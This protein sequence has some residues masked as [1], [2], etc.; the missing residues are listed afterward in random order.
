M[1]YFLKNNQKYSVQNHDMVP[2]QDGEEY[3]AKIAK[4][5]EDKNTWKEMN[6]TI[7]GEL[8]MCQSVKAQLDK[9]VNALNVKDESAKLKNVEQCFKDMQECKRGRAEL[10]AT[11]LS[12][13]EEQKRLRSAIDLANKDA[14]EL[15]QK[16]LK[17]MGTDENGL[18]GL[19]APAP[20]LEDIKKDEIL[21]KRKL[22]ELEKK[23]EDAL[24]P[25]QKKEK[26]V[27]N[28]HSMRLWSSPLFVSS[29]GSQMGYLFVD[30][31]Q[32]LLGFFRMECNY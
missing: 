19:I 21:A 27:K 4:C 18:D 30:F 31:V 2:L 20:T 29:I 26:N 6:A 5:Y 17:C 9:S 11:L 15:K 10:M 7:R 1:A 8:E 16:C 23:Q 13:E 3:A 14:G 32:H 12:S 24:T 25:E 22:E 28:C